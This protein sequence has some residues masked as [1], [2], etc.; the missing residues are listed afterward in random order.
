M[1]GDRIFRKRQNSGDW[2]EEAP[3]GG[4]P[5]IVRRWVGEL[6]TESGHDWPRLQQRGLKMPMPAVRN[7]YRNWVRLHT[8]HPLTRRGVKVNV[9]PSAHSQTT[10]L[11]F[12]LVD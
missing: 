6:H 5:V 4:W 1:S 7:A 11:F 3:K 12:F 2:C 9:P 8:R 10:F